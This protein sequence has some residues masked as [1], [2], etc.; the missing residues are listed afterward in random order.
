MDPNPTLCCRALLLLV[1]ISF[2]AHAS[3]QQTTPIPDSTIAKMQSELG[4]ATA[5]TSSA[6]QKVAL[7]RI[8]REAESLI[9][10]NP[11][12]PNRFEVM[13][14][15]FRT[16]Q[17]IFKQQRTEANRQGILDTC[18]Q[19]SQAPN[20]YADIRWDA[21]LLLSQAQIARQGGDVQQRTSALRDLVQRYLGTSVEK[22]AIRIALLMAV[23]A[24]ESGLIEYL[25]KLISE[26]FADDP[27]MI[28]FKRDKLPSKVFGATFFAELRDTKGDLVRFPMDAFGTTTAFLFWSNDKNG[29]ANLKEIAA[30]LRERTP[31]TERRIAILSI[32]LDGLP[33]A[34]ESILREHGLDW[35]A[36]HLP[37]GRDSPIY[38]AYARVDPK[39]VTVSP[40]GIASLFQTGGNM[41]G[42][43][44]ERWI[45][46]STARKWVDPGY[47]TKLQSLA[48]AEFLIL[49]PKSAFDPA[50]PPELKAL[51]AASTTGKPLLERTARSVPEQTLR[52]IQDCF[53]APPKRYSTPHADVL[54]GYQKAEKLCA[55]AI[56]AHP[57]APD[58]WLVRNRRMVALSGLWK[59]KLDNQFLY[60]AAAEAQRFVEAQHPTGT[61][62]IARLCLARHALHTPE[63]DAQ[64]IIQ[65]LAQQEDSEQP[66][67]PALA[68]AALLAMEC[69]DRDAYTD[70]RQTLL[71][72]HAEQPSLWPLSAFMLDRYHRYWLH[73]IPFVS[74]WIYERRELHGISKF[75]PEPS[76][77]TFDLPLKT[78]EGDEVHFPEFNDGNWT[79]LRF[80][81]PE[82]IARLSDKP[83]PF[84]DTRPFKDIRTF[85]VVLSDDA[86]AIRAELDKRKK[87]THTPMLCIADD[88][89][90]T[91]ERKFGMQHDERRPSILILRPDGSVALAA[92][93][94]THRGMGRHGRI[95]STFFLMQDEAAVDKALANGDLEAAKRIAF[96]NAPIGTPAPPDKNQKRRPTPMPNEHLRS[97]AKVYMALGDW[98][99]A[100][101]DVE[102]VY[103]SLLDHAGMMSMRTEA[104]DKTERIRAQILEKLGRADSSPQAP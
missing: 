70:I 47:F 42:K 71:E 90:D 21:D 100:L 91:L 2:S 95:T 28:A 46:S 94:L 82:Q 76:V 8:V 93:A 83:D 27:A 67:A 102:L 85:D 13:D 36:L 99:A 15:L 41:H 54:A 44:F 7:R 101:A 48:S 72:H 56:E 52:A 53:I 16:Q 77:R 61:D 29:Q 55:Q 89:R 66:T 3:A 38:Q 1:L 11:A 20:E 43:G 17:T 18:K 92:S 86:N 24:G 104:L 10:K 37:G 62:A 96:A 58:L 25:D 51:S 73:Q 50:A 80:T 26:R 59:Q 60:E 5:L 78:I 31:E 35:P 87:P 88:V 45:G 75:E 64:T 30:V 39:F 97:R 12:A 19:L 63:A 74:G 84:I 49:D 9:E 22:K 14:V 68:V 57:N 4:E 69:G 6:R 33:D 81:L 65:S 23:E 103:R 34:G 40:T 32:N 98:E 79:V